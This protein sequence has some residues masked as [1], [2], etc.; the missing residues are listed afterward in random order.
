MGARIKKNFQEF[1]IWKR[2]ESN[3]FF[4]E[5]KQNFDM[6]IFRQFEV[7]NG[8][9]FDDMFC[10]LLSK[11]F[12]E[13]IKNVKMYLGAYLTQL[14]KQKIMSKNDFCSGVSKFISLMPELSLDVPDIH[15][16][17]FQYVIH[18]LMNQDMLDINMVRFDLQPKTDELDEIMF[19]QT[20]YHF[21]LIALIMNNRL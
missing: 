7:Q 20:D 19:E 2:N 6:G 16:Y 1:V 9:N 11:I 15:K 18:P 5:E 14:T 12:D 21:R 10:S 17:L 3:D 13:D 8:K 4:E